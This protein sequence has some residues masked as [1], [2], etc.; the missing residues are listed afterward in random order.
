MILLAAMSLITFTAPVGPVKAPHGFRLVVEQ[1]VYLDFWR[2]TKL[3][4][5]MATEDEFGDE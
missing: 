4:E 3:P 2:Q 1:Q 5:L